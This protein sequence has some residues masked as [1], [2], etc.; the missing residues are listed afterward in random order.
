MRKKR[1]SYKKPFPFRKPTILL[2]GNDEAINIFLK[3]DLN[4]KKWKI[5]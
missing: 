5:I 4:L 2:K 3:A 1:F